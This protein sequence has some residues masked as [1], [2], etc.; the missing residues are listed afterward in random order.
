MASPEDDLPRRRRVRSAACTGLG[1]IAR[2][3][4]VSVA[5][6][7]G[8]ELDRIDV[9]SWREGLRVRDL[10]VECNAKAGSPTAV[11]VA[12]LDL[13]ERGFLTVQLGDVLS[14]DAFAWITLRGLLAAREIEPGCGKP[15]SH[16]TL[17]M[18]AGAKGSMFAARIETEDAEWDAAVNASGLALAAFYVLGV[19]K[20]LK[21][22]PLVLAECQRSFVRL[23]VLGVGPKSG[24]G[25]RLVP[26][27]ESIAKAVELLR[28]VVP[29]AAD[30]SGDKR[31]TGWFL[32]D[33]FPEVR[34]TGAS[35]PQYRDW[36]WMQFNLGLA[37]KG[38]PFVDKLSGTVTPLTDAQVRHLVEKQPQDAGSALLTKGRAV[39]LR[40]LS[41][42]TRLQPPTNL[43]AG[44][45]PRSRC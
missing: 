14:P 33:P 24:P 10:L 8:P 19:V 36:T 18:R 11:R 17:K 13:V 39:G 31:R 22:Q 32:S 43:G 45:K 25:D 44:A 2:K 37:I 5:R 16:V 26:S 30:K 3:V 28:P 7:L 29:I 40:R 15:V 42:L 1:S 9:E 12:L 27:L 20:P 38:T 6:R 35:G 34:V 21:A 41:S 23:A 4:L